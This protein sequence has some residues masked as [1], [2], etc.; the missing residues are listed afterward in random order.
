MQQ[1][2]QFAGHI[3]VLALVLTSFGSGTDWAFASG[4]TEM[5]ERDICSLIKREADRNG[6][7]RAFFARLIWKES[8]FDANAVSPKGAQGIAQFMPATAARRGL[9]NSF[10]PKQAL[11]ASATYLAALRIQFGNLGLAAA[12]YNAGEARIDRWLAGAS[13]LPRET[14]NYVLDITGEAAST[15]RDPR[16]RVNAKPLDE[17]K[18]F[19]EACL[20]MAS[21]ASAFANDLPGLTQPWGV[22][23]AGGYDRAAVV[24]QWDRM[25]IRHGNI[26]DGLPMA[27]SREKS[28]LGSKRIFAVRVGASS[29]VEANTICGRLRA[30]GGHC[31]VKIN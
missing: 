29:R 27:M 30:V 23:I 21:V 25:K 2:K 24:R 4:K 20:Q 13:G 15:F 17:N 19:D 9:E 10:D 3:A 1:L 5:A 26:L 31:V 18:P 28:P 14:E 6:L 11:P 8:R 7:P 12:A 16:Q 22:Q